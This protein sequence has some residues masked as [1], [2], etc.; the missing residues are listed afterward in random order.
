MK[1]VAYEQNNQKSSLERIIFAAISP[2]E[3]IS[4]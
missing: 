2:C 4:H 3:M 1:T